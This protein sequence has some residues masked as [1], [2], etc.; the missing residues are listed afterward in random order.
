MP[1]DYS[2]ISRF[3][4]TE[5]FALQVARDQITFHSVRNVFGT[6]TAIGT[7]FTTPWELA[8]TNPLPLISTASQLD[9]ASSDAGDTTQT[10]RVSG[11]DADYNVV[12]ENIALN[13]TTAVTTVNSYKAINDL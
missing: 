11:V 4:L 2:S 8:N 6:A 10:V 7:S 13:G 1:R 12:A 5:P 9:I 3:G